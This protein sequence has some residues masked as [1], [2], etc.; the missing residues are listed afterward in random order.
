MDHIAYTT[1]FWPFEKKHTDNLL[2]GLGD[3]IWKNHFSDDQKY[4]MAHKAAVKKAEEIGKNVPVI[5][6]LFATAVQHTGNLV[7]GNPFWKEKAVEKVINPA[8]NQTSAPKKAE[9]MKKVMKERTNNTIDKVSRV[10]GS[11]SENAQRATSQLTAAAKNY[12]SKGQTTK[13]KSSSLRGRSKW[14]QG[15]G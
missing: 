2:A 5:G 11:I 7:K 14:A 4:D 10:A 12:S 13:A 3:L 15:R 9:A 6:G 8:Y 1:G